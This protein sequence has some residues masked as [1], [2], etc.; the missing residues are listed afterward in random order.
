MRSSCRADHGLEIDARVGDAQALDAE[1]GSFDVVL[2]HLVLSVVP[3]PG[4]L[5]AETAR[6]LAADGQVSIYD[7]FLPPGSSASLCRRV[8][9]PV[10]RLLFSDLT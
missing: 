1:D 10:A 6:V 3:D 2:L 9:N 4:A 7:K 8:L 5:V